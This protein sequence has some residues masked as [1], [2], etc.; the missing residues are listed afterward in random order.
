MDRRKFFQNFFAAS[1]GMTAAAK[2]GLAEDIANWMLSP[3]KTIFI[4]PEAKV[5][6]EW[7]GIVYSYDRIVLTPPMF[8]G[9]YEWVYAK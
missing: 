3:Q 4:P 2:L 9:A 8:G 6:V 5:V 7:T 1:V